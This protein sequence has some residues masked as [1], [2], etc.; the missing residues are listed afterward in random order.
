[1]KHEC[2]LKITLIIKQVAMLPLSKLVK[3]HSWGSV[4]L[5]AQCDS[6]LSETALGHLRFMCQCHVL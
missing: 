2:A 5:I 1:M 3:L 6:Y 4:S